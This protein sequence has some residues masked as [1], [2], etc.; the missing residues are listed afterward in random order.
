MVA[1]QGWRYHKFGHPEKVLQFEKFR[2]PFDRTSDDVVVK[3]L[4]APVHKNDKSMITGCYGRVR[5]GVM[6]AI[7]GIEGVGVVDEVGTKAQ[8]QLKEGDLVWI[9]NQRVGTFA[10]HIVT[11]AANLDVLPNRADLE[12]E[13][14]S[15][16]ST[17]HAAWHLTH[18]M[19]KLD[20]GDVAL[21]AGA[22]SA[23]SQVAFAYF[24]QLG[25]KAFATM[26]L[27][28][29]NHP[30]LID[31]YKA[32]GAYGIVPY[33]YARSTY[34]RRL[35]ADVPA[36]KLLLNPVGGPLGSCLFKLL[37]DN[38]TV[39]N[40]GSASALPHEIPN[41]DI[42][43]RNIEVRGFFL[44][45]WI[46]SHS[47]ES[48][49]RLHKNVI[50]SMTMTQGKAK[51]YAQRFKMDVDSSYAFL[52]AFDT[53]LPQR[54]S[55]LR[56]VGEYG[57]WRKPTVNRVAWHLGRAIWDDYMSYLMESQVLTDTPGNMKFYTPYE[58]FYQKAVDPAESREI[59]H[60][61]LFMRHPSMQRH[62]TDEAHVSATTTQ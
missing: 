43:R 52:N 5:P 6:P 24:R 31:N 28:R 39:I 11:P 26:Q 57:E 18:D 45:D 38:A 61:P 34:M 3:M 14:L 46:E 12:I 32:M 21:V 36:P 54:K 4:A 8:S 29:A 2:I 42:I 16:M 27:G 48:R 19:V 33:S 47:K 60:R 10:T 30:Q 50:D 49:M 1:S 15:S 37:G 9:N 7:A 35:L 55:I 23:V 22:S 25:V 58:D 56:M 17:F 20:S 51:F 41:M 44:P 59:G 53:H 13:Y 62:N 40:Y